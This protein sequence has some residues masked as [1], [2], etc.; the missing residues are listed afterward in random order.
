MGKDGSDAAAFKWRVRELN[1]PGA[2]AEALHNTGSPPPVPSFPF[3]F[4]FLDKIQNT[5]FSVAFTIIVDKNQSIF[6]LDTPDTSGA[7]LV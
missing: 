5:F 3:Y 2:E 1:L 7:L 6:T 4:T